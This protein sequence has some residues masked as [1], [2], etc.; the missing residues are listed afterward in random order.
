MYYLLF[1][2]IENQCLKLYVVS[3]LKGWISS[4][5][6]TKFQT[7]NIPHPSFFKKNRFFNFKY[8]K[9]KI[10]FK[11]FRSISTEKILVLILN[12][13]NSRKS[14]RI[15]KFLEEFSDSQISSQNSKIL[16]DFLMFSSSENNTRI[17]SRIFLI[18]Q[19]YSFFLFSSVFPNKPCML[20]FRSCQ[21]N[22][23]TVSGRSLYHTKEKGNGIL[24]YL[25][26]PPKESYKDN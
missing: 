16:M 6:K 17:S 26:F 20:Y 24:N 18:T 9:F 2:Q 10:L 19:L 12:E 25:P 7:K 13:E 11:T 15:F 8:L 5:A 22:L 21:Q 14:A 3:N 23:G 1:F 4:F